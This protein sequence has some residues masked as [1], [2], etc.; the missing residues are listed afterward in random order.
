M[1]GL[2][3][4]AEKIYII[5]RD[6]GWFDNERSFDADIALIHGEVSEAHEEWRGNHEPSERYYSDKGKPEGIPSE[7]ADIIVRVL[8]TAYRYGINM[9]AV[10]T[11]KLEYNRSRG[12][13]HGNKRV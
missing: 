1:T 12:Y 7:L 11:E 6:N 5:N 4:L 8:D 13:K 9:D 2:N 3:D 10:M